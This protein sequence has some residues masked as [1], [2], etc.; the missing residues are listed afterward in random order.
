MMSFPVKA[1]PRGEQF[2]ASGSGVIRLLSVT[3]FFSVL[4]YS[5]NKVVKKK[6]KECVLAP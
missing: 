4:Y 5:G 1:F 2:Q 6:E 3:T